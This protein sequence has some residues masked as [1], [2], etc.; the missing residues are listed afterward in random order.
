MQAGAVA[1]FGQ[2]KPPSFRSAILSNASDVCRGFMR[3]SGIAALPFRQRRDAA[4]FDQLPIPNA[5][6]QPSYS[7]EQPSPTAGDPLGGDFEFEVSVL[8][9][10]LK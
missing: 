2:L 7:A 8:G 4:E 9:L 3:R 1:I 10:A 5:S 6:G